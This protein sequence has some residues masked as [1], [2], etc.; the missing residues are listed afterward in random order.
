MI[1]SP[2]KASIHLA[3]IALSSA[4]SLLADQPAEKQP[5]P[6]QSEQYRPAYHFTP[7]AHW[8]NDPN[9][10][11]YDNGV[12]H[13]FYQYN[14]E[15]SVWGPMHWGHATS[16]DLLHWKERPIALAP[17]AL[18]TIFSGSAVLD[19]DNTS[20]LGKN[21]RAPMV[22]IFTYH[23][24]D[25]LKADQPPQSQGLAYSLDGGENWIK[26]AGNPVLRPDNGQKDFRDPKVFWHAPSR[27]W[28]MALAVGD[29]SEFFGSA[30]LKQWRRLSSF[31][32]GLGPHG[33]VWECPDLLPLRVAGTHK[34]KW[35][36][37]QSFNPGG[38]NGGSATQYFV[39]DFDGKTFKMDPDFARKMQSSGPRWLDWG[40]DNYA[41]VTWSGLQRRDGR[42]LLIGWMNNWDYGE[43]TPTKAWRSA[44][45]L[46]R[47]L[48][49]HQ[50]S[51]GGYALHSLPVREIKRLE[52]KALTFNPRKLSS[53]YKLPLA[54]SMISQSRLDLAFAIETGHPKVGFEMT[55]S[56][57]DSYRFGYD[58][59]AKTFVSDRMASGNVDFSPKFASIDK[60]PRSAQGRI[61]RMS[62]YIDH[63]SIEA[64]LDR[65]ATV[66]TT[67]LFPRLPYTH[68]N[69]FVEGGRAR[70][71]SARVW[72]VG[73]VTKP[74]LIAKRL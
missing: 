35:V 47:E 66:M 37:I 16:Q 24:E 62:F 28:V 8:M 59:S 38:P 6:A 12:Y 52:G 3:A 67:A 48:S 65:G 25:A 29:H 23:Q 10:L 51:G 9:G 1:F 72:P 68:I 71:V 13:L 4:S 36:L 19:R 30:D 34:T 61:V 44:M 46:P 15:A 41:G 39:G 50:E 2:G 21:G 69:L 22:A 31:G 26:Y 43:K 49:L 27:R 40:R 17:D 57:G 11:I 32:A 18:G 5:A 64:F 53:E 70:L 7:Q 58:S 56:L 55:N 54:K 42:A 20:G 60:A 45:T 73:K 74:D 33:A 63:S 14:P